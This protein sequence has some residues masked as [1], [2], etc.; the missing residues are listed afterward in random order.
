[1][2]S[3][4]CTDACDSPLT[5]A[6]ACVP[7]AAEEHTEALSGAPAA[8]HAGVKVVRCGQKVR[9]G[10]VHAQRQHDGLRWQ[11]VRRRSPGRLQQQPGDRPPGSIGAGLAL[12]IGLPAQALCR[13]AIKQVPAGPGVPHNDTP[14]QMA[15]L[16]ES[17]EATDCELSVATTSPGPPLSRVSTLI[18][19]L[20]D[21]AIKQVWG[22]TG[23]AV[24][25]H[26]L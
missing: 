20:P 3:P 24:W 7:L 4:P 16:V 22:L 23:M 5:C 18:A 6:S 10:E 17:V 11:L 19:A 2:Q 13:C 8:A 1:M 9:Q 21:D 25:G 26:L 14:R 15:E 12:G